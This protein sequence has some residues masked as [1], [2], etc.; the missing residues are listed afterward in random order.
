MAVG[1]R[2]F[3]LMR[4]FEAGNLALKKRVAGK[5]VTEATQQLQGLRLILLSHVRDGEKN[6][7]EGCEIVAM[8]GGQIA[9]LKFRLACLRASRPCAAS[10][11]LVQTCSR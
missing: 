9:D 4:S 11:A 2:V 5:V 10:S 3:A 6:A 8:I 1:A 7:R